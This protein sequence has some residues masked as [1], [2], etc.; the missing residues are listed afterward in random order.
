MTMTHINNNNL[1]TFIIVNYKSKNSLL[2]CLNDLIQL[3]DI[4]KCEIIIVNNDNTTLS[5][6][7]YN[8]FKIQI[9]ES[10]TNI[11]Y[12]RANNLGLLYANGKYICFLN[13]DTH[14][15]C[16]HFIQIV[17]EIQNNKII[18]APQIKTENDNVEPWSVGDE[19]TLTQLIKNKCNLHNKKWL[20]QKKCSVDWVSGA[21][22]FVSKKFITE[23]GGFDEDFFL[24]FEDVDLC[25]R[26]TDSG[27]KIY[28]LP[29]YYLTHTNGVSSKHDVQKQKKC[30][31]N[32]QDLFFNKHHSALHTKILRICRRLYLS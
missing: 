5:L 6:P 22:L 25:K 24:Y 30:Y 19:I 27:G 1:I 20:S 9:I 11:G 28:Y 14:S 16:P 4:N 26:A 21:A 12:G 32:S 7:K 18:V 31:Y 17:Q 29:N 2:H 10:K 15:F 23:L 3:P 13:P 8:S